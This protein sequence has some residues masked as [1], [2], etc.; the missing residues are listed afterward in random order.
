MDAAMQYSTAQF[1]VERAGV[2]ALLSTFPQA[3]EQDRFELVGLVRFAPVAVVPR[4]TSKARRTE[5]FIPSRPFGYD[6]V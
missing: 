4:R 5:S 6:Q 1:L 3:S 2:N